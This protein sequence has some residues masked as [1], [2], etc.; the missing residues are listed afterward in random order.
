MKAYVVIE[1]HACENCETRES[2]CEGPKTLWGVA[3]TREAAEAKIERLRIDNKEPEWT[4]AAEEWR[5]ERDRLDP[6]PTDFNF[7]DPQHRTGW[8][9]QLDEMTK[10]V[11]AKHGLTEYN[12]YGLHFWPACYDIEEVEEIE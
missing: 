11:A 2:A 10:K 6:A 1:E 5:V 3:K 7:N 4:L 12:Q 9:A 8:Y